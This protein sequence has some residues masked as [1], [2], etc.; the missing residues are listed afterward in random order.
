MSSYHS[1]KRSRSHCHAQQHQ[2]SSV[3]RALDIQLGNKVL[4]GEQAVGKL[5]LHPCSCTPSF[6]KSCSSAVVQ[7]PLR[8]S[9]RYIFFSIA[10]IRGSFHSFYKCSGRHKRHRSETNDPIQC[11]K[12]GNAVPTRQERT[13]RT[14]VVQVQPKGRPAAPPRS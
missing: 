9:K 11:R 1:R 5:S 6:S 10:N 8:I 4:R 3:E 14:P 12:A 13:T 7:C 2:N